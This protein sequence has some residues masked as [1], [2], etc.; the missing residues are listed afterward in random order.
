MADLFGA[1]VPDAWKMDVLQSCY[2]APQHHYLFLTKD[3]IGYSIWPD[4]SHPGFSCVDPY[5]EN[6]WLGV[7]YTGNERLEGHYSAQDVSDPMSSWTNF[8]YLWRMSDSI[9]PT[10]AHKFLSI[11]PLGCDICEAID[12]REGGRLLEHFLLPRNRKS[13]FE[14]V[15]VGAETGKRE[16]KVIPK[17][18]WIEK[19]VTLC[20]LAGIPLFMKSSLCDVWGDDLI[21]EFPD[22]L[23]K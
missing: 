19:L 17:R 2:A 3:P 22:S 14:W 6:M 13:Y 20:H 5:T 12:E 15:I 8:W 21:Q 23:L 1:W 18:E 11:E 10:R 4:E 9:L 7:T 16:G